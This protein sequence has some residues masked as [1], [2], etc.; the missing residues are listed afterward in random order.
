MLVE[1]AVVESYGGE[2]VF[3]DYVPDHSTS[4]IVERIRSGVVS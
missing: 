3:A 1:A 4:G 2:V